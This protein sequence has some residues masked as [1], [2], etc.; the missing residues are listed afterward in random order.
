MLWRYVD[1]RVFDYFAKR[2]EIPVAV[3]LAVEVYEDHAVTWSRSTRR[4][5][6]MV[7][8]CSF[9]SLYGRERVK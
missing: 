2:C 8:G 6:G 4:T 3:V 5:V 1:G 9:C 7:D